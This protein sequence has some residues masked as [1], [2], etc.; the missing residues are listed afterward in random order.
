VQTKAADAEKVRYQEYDAPV[1]VEDAE[2]HPAR[3]NE[4]FFSDVGDVIESFG[5]DADGHDVDTLLVWGSRAIEFHLDAD[6]IVENALE[7]HHEDAEVST[8]DVGTLQELLDD[9]VSTRSVT[10]YEPDYGVLVTGVAEEIKQWQKATELEN[11]EKLPAYF[12]YLD[13]KAED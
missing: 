8:R 3:A 7:D 13:G 10:S 11:T 1:F 2:G 4:G 12:R 5:D 6:A 9:W